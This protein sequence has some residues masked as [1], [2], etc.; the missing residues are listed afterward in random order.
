MRRTFPFGYNS[1][2]LLDQNDMSVK[3]IGSFADEIFFWSKNNPNVF[4]GLDNRNFNN[5]SYNY[6]SGLI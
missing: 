5:Y 6:D 3:A 2:I 4:Y 1:N